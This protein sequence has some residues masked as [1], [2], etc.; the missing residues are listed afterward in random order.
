M[1]SGENGYAEITQ[2]TEETE[3]QDYYGFI[4]MAYVHLYNKCST[5]FAA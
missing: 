1:S 5:S 4:Y 3:Q 2:S